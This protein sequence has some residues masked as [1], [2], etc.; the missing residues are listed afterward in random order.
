M[1]HHF[2]NVRPGHNR[3]KSLSVRYWPFSHRQLATEFQCEI[4][5]ILYGLSECSC[6]RFAIAKEWH[7]KDAKRPRFQH[8]ALT[9]CQKC[10]PT[11]AVRRGPTWCSSDMPRQSGSFCAFNENKMVA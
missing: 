2:H 3:G 1:T 9:K 10:T 5:R 7:G 8:L 11:R 6:D 4:A